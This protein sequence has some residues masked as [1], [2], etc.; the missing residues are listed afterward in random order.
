[1]P[2]EHIYGNT[3]LEPNQLAGYT[4]LTFVKPKGGV[5]RPKAVRHPWPEKKASK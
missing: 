1:M 5:G 3:D 4:R 2:G